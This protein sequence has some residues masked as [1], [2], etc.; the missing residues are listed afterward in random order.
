LH[1]ATYEKNICEINLEEKKR[2]K[3]EKLEEKRG[4]G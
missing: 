4:S 1:A 3:I 2:I